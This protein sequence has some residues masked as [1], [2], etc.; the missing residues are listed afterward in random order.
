MII[1]MSDAQRR[2]FDPNSPGA[3]RLLVAARA[4]LNPPPP[5]DALDP[6]DIV[7]TEP[8]TLRGCHD[9]EAVARRTGECVTVWRFLAD[10]MVRDGHAD[11]AG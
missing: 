2:S 3:Q 10:L 4:A 6:V 5:P 1:G 8:W 11:L 7:L 9:N